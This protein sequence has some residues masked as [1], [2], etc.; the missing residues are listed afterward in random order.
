MSC[1]VEGELSD[2]VT[3]LQTHRHSATCYKDRNNHSCRF[4]FPRPISNESKCLGSD[5]TLA[6]QG[7]FCVL[8]RKESEVMINNYNLV[9]LEL[10]QANMDIQPCGNVTAVAY[11]IAKYASK[12]EPNDCG[13]VV[14][15]VVQK[16]KRH[17][18]D[19]WK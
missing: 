4:G 8:R 6:N 2:L 9:L 5:E 1:S 10:W 7:R 15:E 17:S 11:Y 14:R 19:V 12:C 18:N 3:R 16:A 13:D